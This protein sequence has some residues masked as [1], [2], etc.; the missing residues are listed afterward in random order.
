[1]KNE[2]FEHVVVAYFP[3]KHQSVE[4]LDL[5]LCCQTLTIRSPLRAQRRELRDLAS[6]P[7]A[8]QG[9]ISLVVAP[10]PMF[11]LI[12]FPCVKCKVFFTT[13]VAI[14]GIICHFESF[15]GGKK[16]K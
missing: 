3:I 15:G 13:V 6:V 11:P 14:R 5:L 12:C 10:Y 8:R 7:E 9:D 16:L 4:A 2:P 1:M